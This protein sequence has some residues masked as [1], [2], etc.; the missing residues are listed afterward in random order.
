MK[1]NIM[2]RLSDPFKRDVFKRTQIRLTLI[3]SALIM[4]FLI[5]FIVID[6]TL[7]YQINSNQ[8]EKQIQK[9]A[10]QELI[11][12]KDQLMRGKKVGPDITVIGED[13]FF[14]YVVN[15]DGQL[16]AGDE[17]NPRLREDLLKNLIGWIPQMDETRYQTL[18]ETHRHPWEQRGAIGESESR[19]I[20]LLMAG[21][22]IYNGNQLIG[23]FYIG[24]NISY[25]YGLYKLLLII[26]SILAIV[27]SGVAVF[28][29]YIM[30]KRA[31]IPIIQAYTRQR[32]FT[33][34]A[35]HELRTP[36]SVMLSSINALEMENSIEK[37]EFSRSLLSNMKDE[38][39]RMTKLVAH[40]LTLARSD[41]DKIELFVE[42]FDFRS[43]VDKLIQT[44]KPLAD[45]KQ[46]I[47]GLHA[48]NALVVYADRERLKQLLYILL[49]NG[50]K[51]TPNGGEV[52]LTLSLETYKQSK[53]LTIAVRDTG[54]GIEPE[55]H[56]RIF[57]RFYRVD[58]SRSRQM[59]GHGLGLAIAKAII[60]SHHGTIHVESQPGQGTTFMIKIPVADPANE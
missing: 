13:Q 6:Y 59:G 50:I 39:K 11:V 42:R 34:D 31:M 52:D 43:D 57:E 15:S 9:L 58:P 27:F 40:L 26:L 41:S 60:D 5:L 7:V 32:E 46:I 10:D 37:D 47:V 12:I 8:Q 30:S 44:I 36:L 20:R 21:R 51:Y 23:V 38:V 53:T 22:P 18:K 49:E 14:Y 4:L 25:Q 1:F 19:D 24:K 2:S 54:I 48:P 28:I 17:V 56:H 35:S 33:A 55:H 29:S 3:Y 16:I 45:S